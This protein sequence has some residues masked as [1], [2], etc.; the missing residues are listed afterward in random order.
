MQ[1]KDRIFKL[2]TDLHMTREQFAD[3]FGVSKQ[4]VQK[5]ESG[6][7]TPDLSKFIA[8]SKRF[9]ISL[10]ALILD[11]D[12]RAV[13]D[14]RGKI[15]IIPNYQNMDK[16]EMYSTAVQIEYRQ[17]MDEGLDLERYKDV[18][19]A[20]STLPI[21]RIKE[22][23]GE[24]IYEIV[25]N[26]D[27]R[28][29]YPY[30]E[31]SKLD[32]IKEL[33]KPYTFKPKF[34]KFDKS[35]LESK[36]TGAWFGR[37]CGCLLGKSLEGIRTNELV[38]L[39]K[40]TGNYPMHR[41]VLQSDIDKVDTD[42][43]VFRLI[44][45][46]YADTITCMPY[47]DDTNYTVLAQMIIYDYGKHFTPLNVMQAWVRYQPKDS[48]CTAEHVAF[49]NFVQGYEP[50]CSAIYKNPY[51]EW[52]GAQIRA[53]YYGYIN[54]GDPEAAADMAWRDA[55]ISHVKNGI[56]SAMFVAAALAAAAVTDN[57]EDVILAGL[58]EIPTTSRLYEALMGVYNG[59]KNG[60]TEKECFR[61]IHEEFDEHSNYYWCLALSNS[62]IVVAS[63]L[64]GNGD[65]GRSICMA[66]EAGF[67]TDCNGA[68][69]GSII[70]MT[71]GIDNIPECWTKPLNNTL[72]TSIFHVGTVSITDRVHKTMD[73]IEW[74]RTLK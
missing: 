58:A 53:D 64:Y 50:P 36:L 44:N 60:V 27:Q 63:L 52:I 29:G 1:L 48:Y 12:M 69:V 49:C 38:P 5:W 39:L 66:N 4:A 51:R 9:D 72:E 65:Y 59:Y 62:V 32:E 31:P 70:G 73:Q 24:V 43:Y 46:P 74:L 61:S 25:S 41:Y 54:P 23:F 68:T 13:E 35:V 45:Q 33:R 20:I 7:A 19:L 21:G 10:D 11:R 34:D 28:E 15:K 8:M 22:R 2:R 3:E 17:G 42:K 18:F 30:T 47:D 67:D 55:S 16:W 40:E 26:A 57:I 71:K 56:Y 6:T 37:I 14:D